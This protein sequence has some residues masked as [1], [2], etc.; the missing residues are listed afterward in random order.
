M[1]SFAFFFLL[2][3]GALA[4]AADFYAGVD[5]Y[6]SASMFRLADGAPESDLVDEYHSSSGLS[7]DAAAVSAAG[8]GGYGQAMV[9]ATPGIIK[10]KAFASASST[11]FE[12]G[13][14][15]VGVG[16]GTGQGRW[17]DVLTITQS[18]FLKF[19]WD[20][21]GSASRILDTTYVTLTGRLG[22][23]RENYSL[24][25]LVDTYL[26]ATSLAQMFRVNNNAPG[27]VNYFYG[28][29]TAGQKIT[30]YADLEVRAAAASYKPGSASIDYSH[31][32]Y[33]VIE[34]AFGQGASFTSAS[35]YSY[36]AQPVPE[37]S[38]LAAL[39]LGTVVLLRRRSPVSSSRRRR[40]R[41][42]RL[43]S[44]VA[45]PKATSNRL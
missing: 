15:K 41:W 9:S 33:A 7:S 34:P 38:A 11:T 19:T 32:S 17:L 39:G 26:H 29:F 2:G 6:A 31:S 20:V 45:L 40:G 12:N 4:P 44:E 5:A 36:A 8:I 1:R 42:S 35:G 37:P 13:D 30:V 10:A 22:V 27:N 23:V 18:G 25:G 28:S 43:F 14:T 3:L 21:S 24:V 16:N